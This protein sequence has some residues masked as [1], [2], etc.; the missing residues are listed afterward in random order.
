MPGETGPTA[1]SPRET[2][3]E[4]VRP[5]PPEPPEAAA[6]SSRSALE[7]EDYAAFPKS[8]PNPLPN[9]AR[10]RRFARINY[11]GELPDGSRRMYV[12]D[13][14]G[15]LYFIVDGVV[16][17]YLD[18]GSTFEP[19]FFASVGLGSGLGFVTFHPEFAQNGKFY[20]THTEA[21]AALQ[22]SVPDLTPQPD[23][24]F[25]SV[26]T[27]WIADDPTANTFTG[28]SREVLRLGFTFRIHHIQ[29][30]SFN[31]TATNGSEDYGLLYLGV[32]DGGLGV[33]SD[34][35]Q[36]LTTPQG[37]ILRIDPAGN[38]SDNGNYGIPGDNPFVGDPAALGEIYAYGLRDPHRFSWDSAG[39]HRMFLAHIGEHDFESLYDVLPGDN[40]GWS[41]REG[42]SVHNSADMCSSLSPL[43]ADDASFGYAYPLAEYSHE[44]PP[45]LACFLDAGHAISGGFMYRG[46]VEGLRGKYIFGDL[47][48]GRVMYVEESEMRRNPARGATIHLLKVIDP[49]GK[50]M[51]VPELVGDTRVDLRF[52]TDSGN[53]LYLLS[54]A[55]GKIWRV[56][57]AR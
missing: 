23:T 44:R 29:Q 49:S 27:E 25:H 54:K 3:P 39:E 42:R 14:N 56:T 12:P 46:P 24:A 28:T 9:D 55:N 19:E 2:P 10:L 45:E 52:G 17:P 8:D 15:M 50:E 43:P 26:I 16:T 11:L 7:L 6:P 32:G 53:N 40:F 30:I 34:E 20:T 21:D 4:V 35:P 33:E 31:P 22:D 47:V 36:D 41:E 1:P 5:A 38:D 51:T 37:K 13:L 57:G 18:V 48:D